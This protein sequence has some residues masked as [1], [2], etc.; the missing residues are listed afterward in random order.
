M[1]IFSSKKIFYFVFLNVVFIF[2][3]SLPQ[4]KNTDF[5]ISRQVEFSVRKAWNHDDLVSPKLKI[6]VMDDASVEYAGATE[7]QESDLVKMLEAVMREH[8]QDI[9]LDQIFGL[10]FK[11]PDSFKKLASIVEKFQMKPIVGSYLSNNKIRGREAINYSNQE[12]TMKNF[13]SPVLP[14]PNAFLYGPNKIFQNVFDFG[15][16]YHLGQGLFYPVQTLGFEEPPR[17]AISQVALTKQFFQISG[18]EF[19][20]GGKKI[21]LDTEGRMMA[22]LKSYDYFKSQIF[23]YQKILETISQNKKLEM[24]QEGDTV[25]FVPLFFTGGADF[26]DT[27]IGRIPG[28]LIHAAILNSVLTKNWLSFL[29]YPWAAIISGNLVG[30]F[31]ANIF[32]SFSFNLAFI[33]L[34][35]LAIGLGNILFSFFQLMIPWLQFNICFSISAILF[36]MERQRQSEIHVIKLRSTLKGLIPDGMLKVLEDKGEKFFEEPEQKRLTIMFIDIVGFSKTSVQETAGTVFRQLKSNISFM[37]SII[38]KNAGIVDK[39][40]GDGMLAFFGYDENSD[41]KTHIMKAVDTAIEIQNEILKRSVRAK[42]TDQLIFP[43]RIGLNTANVFIGNIGDED[44]YD[45]TIIGDG[46]NFAKRLEES[47]EPYTILMGS[48]VYSELSKET[49]E[50]FSFHRRYIHIKHQKEIT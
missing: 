23:S 24:I 20:I 17:Y 8:P 19:E 45:I 44:R 49:L 28:G 33:S 7:V 2:L 27:P 5:L 15:H 30:L 35:F 13:E 39:T 47:C 50:K 34:N 38:H 16:I 6:L 43:V 10:P 41:S 14:K 3:N 32:K 36:Y 18:R 29:D 11:N 12:F 22:N 37:T 40:L 46:V 25:L 31:L 26:K 21:Q 48:D 9:Y 4:L 1:R 42:E